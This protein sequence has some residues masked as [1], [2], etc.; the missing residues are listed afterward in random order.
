MGK[1]TDT[2]KREA[3]Y[4]AKVGNGCVK[5]FKLI[6]TDGNKVHTTT[7]R[8]V[9]AEV[10]TGDNIGTYVSAG[11]VIAGGVLLGPLGAVVGALIRK[12]HNK[13]YVVLERG[14]STIGYIEASAKHMRQLSHLAQRINA[15]ANDPDNLAPG[16]R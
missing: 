10:V 14:G 5:G 15:S 13:A 12:N 4:Y 8:G 7:T 11:R 2:I 9:H 16:Q 3:K 6:Y 1:F